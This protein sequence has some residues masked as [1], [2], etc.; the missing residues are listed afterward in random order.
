MLLYDVQC[1]IHF[2]NRSVTEGSFRVERRE[3]RMHSFK[4]NRSWNEQSLGEVL[5]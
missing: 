4:S 2:L 5:R 1:D 3:Y